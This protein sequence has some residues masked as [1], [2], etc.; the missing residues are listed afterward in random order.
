M[1]DPR[2]KLDLY[3]IDWRVAA[4]GFN[5]VSIQFEFDRERMFEILSEEI[6]QGDPYVFLREL[7]QNSIDAIRMRREVLQ[8]KG[9]D[10]EGLGVIRVAI[11]HGTGGDAIVIWQDDGIGMDEYIVRNYLAVAGKSYYTSSDFEREGLKMDPISRFGVGILSCFMVADRVQIET[12]KD[13]YLPTRGDPIRITIPAVRRQFRI[14][15]LPQES[16]QVGTIVRVFVQG[17]K[18]PA[19]EQGKPAQPLNVTGYLS[20][21]AGF[22]EFPIVIQEG[23]RKTIVLHPKQDAKAARQ[24]FGGDFNVHQLDLSYPWTK[25][26]FPQ[27]MLAAREMLREECWDIASALG[28]KDYEGSLTYLIPTDG[29]VDLQERS[30]RATAIIRG[31]AEYIKKKTRWFEEWEDYSS[32][33]FF[34]M[35]RS[36]KYS[37]AYAVYR[38]GILV[39]QASHPTLEQYD[40]LGENALQVPRLEVNI[41]KSQT[42]RVDLS[43]TQLLEQ[44]KRWDAPIL[45]AHRRLLVEKSFKHLLSL[46]SV[47]R[48]YQ[49]GRLIAFHNV[50]LEKL[51][52][53]FPRDY[54]PVLIFEPE[55]RLNALE[56]KTVASDAL[57]LFPEG[58]N[59]LYNIAHCL[60]VSK[61]EYKGFLRK[62]KGERCHVQHFGTSYTHVSTAAISMASKL[63]GFAFQKSHFLAS[64]RFLKPPLQDMAPLAQEIWVPMET[65]EA[66]LA[67]ELLLEKTISDPTQLTV[68]KKSQLISSLS[69]YGIY[70]HTFVEFSKPFE[71]AFAYGY[72]MFNTKH[73]VTQM[74]IRVLSLFALSKIR[75]ILS[76]DRLGD[77]HDALYSVVLYNKTWEEWEDHLRRFWLMARQ[78]E[79]FL[80]DNL[81]DLV[82]SKE[83]FVPGSLEDILFD[84]GPRGEKMDDVQ[85]FGEPLE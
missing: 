83:E 7:L 35:S 26:F 30:V 44:Y 63:W 50:E 31:R 58:S 39:S 45:E 5:P 43:R 8:R 84:W 65:P 54:W 74:L 2:H 37:E 13:P 24:R 81:E 46:E 48:W 79:L 10:P 66:P 85:P 59:E 71:D 29:D 12:F 77:L 20:I 57:Y 42:L 72:H 62:W 76:S 47:E 33:K 3:H 52:E 60:W 15:T 82:P 11:E 61:E 38:D 36:S 68:L 53:I 9:I 23:D 6:Y 28:L 73:P 51:W 21:V 34:G 56:W 78:T 40:V 17:E 27:D 67:T 4:R 69:R 32:V 70:M 80:G 1:N 55:C 41:P 75:K 18:I 19:K 16:A 64:I 22:V 25:V 49:L 14:E